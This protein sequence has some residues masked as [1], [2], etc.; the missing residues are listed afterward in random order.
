VSDGRFS[1]YVTLA[2]IVGLGS[3][4]FLL[5]RKCWGRILVFPAVGLLA[6]AAALSGARS[7]FLYVLATSIVLPVGMIW[8]APRGMGQA[9]R[10]VKAIRRSFIFVALAVSLAVTL[11][12]NVIGARLAFYRETISPDSPN[13]EVT[14]RAWDYPVQNL[15]AVFSDRG[16]IT[17]HGVGTA[18]L[19]GQYVSRFM[20]VPATDVATENGYGTLILELGILGPILW[21][22]WTSSLVFAASRIVVK[23]KGTW[24][25]P[26]ALSITWYAFILLF[27]LTWGGLV[28]YQNFISN[29][30]LWLLIGV[31]FRLPDLVRPG[32]FGTHSRALPVRP[33]DHSRG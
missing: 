32:V 24:A 30:Y 12:P 28:Q 1:A 9:Y 22:L 8:G 27:P 19:G 16:W 5:L 4:G 6:L 3:A 33:I 14:N 21:V 31:L 26:I 11:F 29:A 10:L 15:L 2:F 7:A 13:Y 20:G 17:G 18:S 25:F 23:L